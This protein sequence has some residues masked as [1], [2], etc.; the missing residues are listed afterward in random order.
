MKELVLYYSYTGHVAAIAE[1]YAK[2]K[3]LDCC[4]VVTEKIIGKFEA[5]TAGCFKSMQGTGYPIN[6][7]VFADF[8]KVD[9]SAYDTVYVFAPIWANS[10][11]APINNALR[12][13]PKGTKVRI[14]AVSAGGKSGKEKIIAHVNAMGLN[15]TGFADKKAGG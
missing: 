3:G 15:V 8:G 10:L 4:R 1:D 2:D 9:L 5:Y 6:S 7:L 14:V 13:L 12:E 11:A